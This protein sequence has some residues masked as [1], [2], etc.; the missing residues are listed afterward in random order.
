[1]FSKG[2]KT[3]SGELAPKEVI[4]TFDDGPHST[5]TDRILG[6]L[7][8]VNA[9]ALFFAMGKKRKTPW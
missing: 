8:S 9:K 5:Y 3:F 1:M 2:Y 7:E 6:T 4:L